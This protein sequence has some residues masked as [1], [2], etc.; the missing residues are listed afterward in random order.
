MPETTATRIRAALLCGA[1]LALPSS[2]LA[3]TYWVSPTGTAAWAACRSDA[4][5]SGSAACALGTANTNAVAG[6]V[7]YFRGGTYIINGD[8]VAGI[9]PAQSGTSSSNMITFAAHPGETP[10]ILRGTGTN[11]WGVFLRG[12]SYFKLEGFTVKNFPRWAQIDG[13]SHHNEFTRNTFTGDTGTEGWQGFLIAE[14]CSGGSSFRCP[15]THNWVHHN[16]FSKLH[17]QDVQSPCVEGADLV[18]VGYENGTGDS[19]FGNDYNTIESNVMF[20]AGHSTFDGYGLYTVF[21]DNI[22]HNEPWWSSTGS[23]CAYANDGYSNPA[24]LGKYGHRTFQISDGG[25]RQGTFALIEGNRSGFG[26]A[27]PGNN[28]ANGMDIAS[29]RNIVRFNYIF[30][31][32]NSCLMFKYGWVAGAGGNGGTYNRVYN[33]TLYHCGFGNPWYESPHAERQS[34]SPEP[35]LAI[36]FYQTETVGNVVK[37]NLIYDSRRHALSGFDIGSGANDPSVGANSVVTNNWLTAHGNPKFVNPDVR[38][39]M[40]LVLPNLALQPSSGAIDAGT[41]LTTALGTAA[42]S[43]VLV[44]RDALYFQDGTWGSDLARGVT[45]FPDWISI[46][47]PGNAVPI[48]SINYATN[49]ITLAAATSWADG[50]PIWLYKKSDGARVLMGTGPDLGASE[51][52]AGGPLPPAGLRIIR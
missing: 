26:S 9:E 50:A 3:G 22:M 12:V 19:Q 4:P 32:M 18:R 49:T 25:H 45:L 24:F 47:S 35:L 36:R 29:P 51:F 42:G 15:S 23:G 30:S 21:R 13:S 39:P 11:A 2:A 33:N 7:V 6:D 41:F 31:A 17:A 48:R 20:H 37:N 1:C 14:G 34:T 52:E 16:T 46:G 38:D 44:V 10:L 40:S 43:T 27:N 8:H 5:L 28:G